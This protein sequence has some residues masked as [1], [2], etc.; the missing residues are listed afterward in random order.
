[1]ENENGLFRVS[2]LRGDEIVDGVDL[3]HVIDDKQGQYQDHK[4]TEDQIQ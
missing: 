3:V 2:N 4:E 1:M